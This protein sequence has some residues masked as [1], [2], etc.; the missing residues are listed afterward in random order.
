MRDASSTALPSPSTS[1]KPRGYRSCVKK[2]AFLEIV[3]ATLVVG[4]QT[5]ESGNSC[6]LGPRLW[7]H[8]LRL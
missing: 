5:F 1:A 7:Q 4:S 3:L 6:G 8:P 2:P